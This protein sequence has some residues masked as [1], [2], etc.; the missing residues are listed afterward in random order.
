MVNY[1]KNLIIQKLGAMSES[2]IVT[3]AASCSERLLPNYKKFVDVE[4]WGD[5]SFFRST[6][7]S[8]WNFIE[9]Q[10][11]SDENLKLLMKKCFEFVPDSEEFESIYA[12]Y[13]IDFGASIYN[14]LKYCLEKD[15][16]NIISVADA[17]INTVDL[18]V[19]EKHNLDP[20][21]PDLEQKINND[22]MMQQEII[23]QLNDLDIL[24]K[25]K[26]DQ[27]FINSFR[28]SVEG[29]SNIEL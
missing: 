15:I 25:Q 26:I 10:N 16:K 24:A 22:Q 29:K 14:T 19:Q 20:D 5:Y 4:Q 12:S 28:T 3:F 6:L 11:I 13:A 21:D 8:I 18:F 2:Q 9:Q 7:N 17:S 1:D 23:K 27:Q